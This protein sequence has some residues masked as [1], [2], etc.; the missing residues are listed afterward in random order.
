MVAIKSWNVDTEQM[1]RYLAWTESSYI[2]SV[3]NSLSYLLFSSMLL[4]QNIVAII[5]IVKFRINNIAF[6]IK[7]SFEGHSNWNMENMDWIT[8]S[9]YETNICK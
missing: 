8:P 3:W 1:Q 4:S 7:C 5:C 2:M 9:C 6:T